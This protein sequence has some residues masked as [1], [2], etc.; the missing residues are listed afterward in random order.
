M[1][2]DLH[3]HSNNSDGRFSIS[4][5][6]AEA[7]LRGISLLSI[8]DHDSI[9]GQS[10]TL[11]LARKKKIRC[12][13][14]VELN[15]TFSFSE[16]KDGRSVALDFLGYNF[17]ILDSD[18]RDKLKHM[19]EYRAQRAMTILERLNA[20][21]GKQGI[22]Q[23][24]KEDFKDIQNSVEG[25]L[26]RP[27]IA[28]YLIRKGIVRDRQEAFDKY[29]VKLNVPKHPLF[30]EE[31]SRLIRNAGGLIVLA[32]PNDPRGTSLSE[33]T[34]SLSEQTTIIEEAMLSY[35]DGIECWHSRSNSLTTNHYVKFSKEH[36]LIMT[37]GSDCHQK[38]IMMGRTKV[39]D[40]VAQQ[41]K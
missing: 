37:G 36:K 20:E 33:L 39:P 38:P 22:T 41:F 25:V 11:M 34:K 15:V 4:E 31:A 6:L 1:I 14:G 13:P 28:D 40:Y 32:H 16:Y 10:E 26:G 12:I 30:L 8:T 5:I 17:D 19:V 3:I 9:E 35:I 23:L 29:L 18:L 2:L 24:T 7:A 27:H 21:F